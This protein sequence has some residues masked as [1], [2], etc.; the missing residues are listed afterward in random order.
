MKGR[1]CMHFLKIISAD[2]DFKF[3]RYTHRH[4]YCRINRAWGLGVGSNDLQRRIQGGQ[5]Q[6]YPPSPQSARKWRKINMFLD[7]AR[8]QS[9]KKSKKLGL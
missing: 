6:S 1:I 8:K 3:R 9:N 5:T 7:I 2:I 4:T